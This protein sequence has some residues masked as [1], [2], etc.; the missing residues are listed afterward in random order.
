VLSLPEGLYN[1]S[2][3][4]SYR[5]AEML[6]RLPVRLGAGITGQVCVHV[7]E[8]GLEAVQAIVQS[9]QVDCGHDDLS[10]RDA[11]RVGPMAGLV[12]PLSV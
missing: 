7:L 10:V 11:Q 6:E 9:G 2:H 4:V 8:G 3:Q 5:I 12:G 1:R